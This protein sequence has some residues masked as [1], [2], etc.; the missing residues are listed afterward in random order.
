[1]ERAWRI[2]T[3]TSG[4]VRP[5]AQDQ[6]VPARDEELHPPGS[7]RRTRSVRSA[8]LSRYAGS[9]SAAFCPPR[10][11]WGAG[12]ALA[13]EAEYND[14]LDFVTTHFARGAAAPAGA[15]MS[16]RERAAG[17]GVRG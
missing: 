5:R 4:P 9:R 14:S 7:E 12:P 11:R 1:M 17:T 16:G 15:F 2:S 6:P 10:G 3:A 13:L 8:S